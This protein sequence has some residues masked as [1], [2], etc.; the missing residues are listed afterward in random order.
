MFLICVV[1][2][3]FTETDDKPGLEL[4][5]FPKGLGNEDS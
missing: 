5:P 4:C 1:V 2:D 3:A